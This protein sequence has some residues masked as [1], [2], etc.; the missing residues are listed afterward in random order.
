MIWGKFCILYLTV[1]DCCFSSCQRAWWYWHCLCKFLTFKHLIGQY[2]RLDRFDSS[3]SGV[4]ACSVTG[5]ANLINRNVPIGTPELAI[6]AATPSRGSVCRQQKVDI[7]SPS[8]MKY[9]QNKNRRRSR[10]YAGGTSDDA[11]G[12]DSD[13]QFENLEVF[14]LDEYGRPRASSISNIWIF[15][16]VVWV[17]SDWIHI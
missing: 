2:L 1:L 5:E 7:D 11:D 14:E 12:E 15:L 17:N 3:V 10:D 8:N 9:R 13:D 4:A 6:T 16:K